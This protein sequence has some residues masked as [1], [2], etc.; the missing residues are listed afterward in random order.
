MVSLKVSDEMRGLMM[1][2]KLVPLVWQA[3]RQVKVRMVLRGGGYDSH[4]NFQFLADDLGLQPNAG[5]AP[6]PLLSV[7]RRVDRRGV[8][9]L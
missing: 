2:E 5:L 9:L 8:G 7:R 6:D 1:G 4:E 3:K